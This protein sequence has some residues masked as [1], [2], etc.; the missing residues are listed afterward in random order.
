M[1]EDLR[2]DA[3]K[4]GELLDGIVEIKCPSRFC[5]AGAGVIVLHRFDLE[6]GKLLETLRF[7][8]PD[9]G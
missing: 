1:R 3:K 6:T 9:R 4:F 8:D 7:R 2:C 5:G